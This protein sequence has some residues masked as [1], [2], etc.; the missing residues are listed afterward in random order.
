ML[1]YY[2]T[3]NQEWFS[4]YDT[5]D[6]TFHNAS[7][8]NEVWSNLPGG[9]PEEYY[10]ETGIDDSEVILKNLRKLL[11]KENVIFIGIE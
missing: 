9:T 7:Y 11:S 1:V 6:P 3:L 8:S 2:L 4:K 10:K 5:N